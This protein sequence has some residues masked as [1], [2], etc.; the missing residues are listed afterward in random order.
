MVKV[1]NEVQF[2]QKLEKLVEVSVARGVEKEMKG[3]IKSL[4]FL[5]KA[6][7]SLRRFVLT[8]TSTP[9]VVKAKAKAGGAQRGR[10]FRVK[11]S[12]RNQNMVKKKKKTTFTDNDDSCLQISL[13]C[14]TMPS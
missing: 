1:A 10:V 3:F 13:A 14:T 9:K 11:C 6:F 8:S 5:K 12:L 7:K 4:D 2:F